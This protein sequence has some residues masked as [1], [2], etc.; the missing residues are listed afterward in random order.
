[1]F[2]FTWRNKSFFSNS[3]EVTF[4]ILNAI[5]ASPVANSG[6]DGFRA[7]FKP[8]ICKDSSRLTGTFKFNMI[9]IGISAKDLNLF[10]RTIK[11]PSAV[12]ID[13]N[14][15]KLDENAAF[16]FLFLFFFT[17]LFAF[18]FMVTSSRQKPP[19]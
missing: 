17:F 1:M 9:I 18:F 15:F 11:F 12:H 6:L 3:R 19:V 5:S 13:P 16:F 8:F 14:L 2:G 4:A 7:N 10:K